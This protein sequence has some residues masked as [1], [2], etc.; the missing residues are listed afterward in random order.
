V[1]LEVELGAAKSP[2]AE[3]AAGSVVLS[4]ASNADDF[5]RALNSYW[6]ASGDTYPST[7]H[8]DSVIDSGGRSAEP[9]CR[10]PESDELVVRASHGSLLSSKTAT[11][12]S[13]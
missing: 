5:S 4:G 7:D 11:A 13:N 1:R 3:L 9:D 6:A 8:V 12:R 2:R 10:G